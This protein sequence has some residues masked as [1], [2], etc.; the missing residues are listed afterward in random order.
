[1]IGE[2]L[3]DLS[4]AAPPPDATAQRLQ[5][6]LGEDPT[7]RHRLGRPFPEVTPPPAASSRAAAATS[8]TGIGADG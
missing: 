2:V 8:A 7:G 1:M 5:R 3:A 4:R 6:V